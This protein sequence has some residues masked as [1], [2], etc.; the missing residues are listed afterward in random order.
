M[1]IAL[2]GLPILVKL[3][4]LHDMIPAVR[5][6]GSERHKAPPLRAEGVGGQCIHDLGLDRRLKRVA[7]LP[8]IHSFAFVEVC[9]KVVCPLSPCMHR[10]IAKAAS[11]HHGRRFN[12][13]VADD[14]ERIQ[15]MNE[16]QVLDQVILPAEN[17]SLVARVAQ[18][19]AMHLQVLGCWIK[20]VAVGAMIPS[21]GLRYD[22]APVR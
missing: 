3:P 7:S 21:G 9:C 11:G 20:H 14:R 6:G 5:A 1:Y 16:P 22:G 18:T 10:R 8:V 19:V 13:P 12:L 15:T 17:V 4:H 2:S